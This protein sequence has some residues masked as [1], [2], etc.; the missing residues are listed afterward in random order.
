MI[1]RII[2]LIT[3]F[4]ALA[5]NLFGQDVQDSETVF[6]NGI[7]IDYGMGSYSVRDEIISK[8]KYSGAFPYFAARWSRIH[9]KDGYCLGLE[10]RSSEKIS[11]HNIDAQIIQFSLY[12]DYFYRVGKFSLFSKH[13][14]AFLSP[15]PEFYFYYNQPNISRNG[16]YGTH[17][18][19]YHRCSSQ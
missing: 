19:S 5:L 15:T 7:T 4:L 17:Q 10:F 12:R 16:L 6:P 18:R 14:Y 9:E 13:V 1:A 11:N 2:T 3:V 8:E